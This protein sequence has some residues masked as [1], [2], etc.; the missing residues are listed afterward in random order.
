MRKILLL[1]AA[2]LLAAGAFA[3]KTGFI[4]TETIFRAI[5]EY[6]EALTAIDAF[7]QQ[8]QAKVDADFTRI[9]EMYERY[10][11]QR[12]G[13]SQNARQQVENNII[14]LEQEATEKQAAI[15]G[16]DGTL[17]KK[18]IELLKP[19]QDKVFGVVDLV[20]KLHQ[21]DAILDIS[22]NPSIV[23]YNAELDLTQEVINSLG[24][25]K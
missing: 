20:G 19:I 9:A 8:E 14:K 2:M 24:I 4:N 6:N 17:M 13:L 23:Y 10:Q 11:E 22:N 25:Q 21:C 3:Q 18:R 7:A 12:Q 5:P 15:F 1:A 16:Q